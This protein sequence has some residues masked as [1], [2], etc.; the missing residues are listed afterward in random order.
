MILLTAI[1]EQVVAPGA[2]V[3]FDA[4]VIG[5]RRGRG[6]CLGGGT[7]LIHFGANV[8]GTVPVELTVYVGGEPLS[9]TV[10]VSNVATEQNVSATTAVKACGCER[11]TVV[12]TGA[13]DVTVTNARLL[14]DR[15]R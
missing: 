3:V 13:A 8:A 4:E 5:R 2:P 7:H 10:M 9:E 6:V 11:V 12:N 1:A 14:I 15:D